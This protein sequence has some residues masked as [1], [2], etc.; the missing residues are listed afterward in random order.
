[1]S[2]I[3]VTVM[4]FF[5]V[6]LVVSTYVILCVYI[7]IYIYIYMC[8]CV[9]VLR[10]GGIFCKGYLIQRDEIIPTL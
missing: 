9:C 5:L 3:H 7:Y 2:N 8:V 1:M 10:E 6:L 4:S